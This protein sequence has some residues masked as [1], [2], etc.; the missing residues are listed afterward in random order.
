MGVGTIAII[1]CGTMG[2]AILKGLLNTDSIRPAQ[3]YVTT[4][5]QER[6][7][8]LSEQYGVHASA[9]NIEAV[10][11]SSLIVLGVKPQMA[12][13]ILSAPALQKELENKM[14]ISICAGLRLEQLS[15]A[16]PHTALIRAMPNTPCLIGEGMTVLSAGPRVTDA[17]LM[18]A[19]EIFSAV[20]RTRILEEKHLDAVTALSGSGPAFGFVMMEAL[21]DGG[22][23]MGLPRDVAV[24][25]SAQTMQ[26]AARLILQTGMHPAAL[27]DDV[28]TPAGCT[29]AGLLTMEDGRIRS[30]LARAIQEATTVAAG[31]GRKEA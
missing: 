19:Q 24:E 20:G 5:R 28:T 3:L 31:L 16:L 15:A 11:Q 18:M 1:G 21:A 14:L 17:H 10:K 2:E 7:Q 4:R 25:L 22:V 6:A 30:I 23:M 27:K 9:D 12:M 29:I 13:S 26:G 8:T